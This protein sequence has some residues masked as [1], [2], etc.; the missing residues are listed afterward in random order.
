MASPTFILLPDLYQHA[1]GRCEENVEQ[2]QPPL[3]IID[4]DESVRKALRHLSMTHTTAAE[5][6]NGV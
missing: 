3:L 2:P 1:Q 4:D 5:R 6:R